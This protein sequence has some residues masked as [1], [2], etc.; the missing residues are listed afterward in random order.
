MSKSKNYFENIDIE[1]ER[2]LKYISNSEK[3]INDL[4]SFFNDI[5]SNCLNIYKSTTK[6]LSSFFDVSKVSEVITKTD[7]NMT[8]FYQTTLIF[9]N[10]FSDIV[11]KINHIIISPL[12]D[13]KINYIK[14]NTA[15]KNDL[16]LLL[17]DYKNEKKQLIL[18]QKEY[19]NSI[20]SYINIKNNYHSLENNKDKNKNYEEQ[21]EKLF[22]EMNEKKCILKNRKQL[23]KYK[24]GATNIFYKNY[25][26][27]YKKYYKSFEKNETNK[28]IF[29]HNTFRIFS[30]KIKEL[31]GV[32]ND[33]SVQVNSKISEWKIE[34]DNNI[35]KDE[36]NYIGRYINSDNIYN[37]SNT[38]QRFN[39]ELF[40]P[41]NMVNMNYINIFY[42]INEKIK[43]NSNKNNSSKSNDT[44]LEQCNNINIIEKNVIL[45]D[46]KNEEFQQNLINKFYE[47]LYN[48]DDIPYDIISKIIECI[49]NDIEFCDKFINKFYLEHK[50]K[51]Y[52]INKDKNIKHL[53]HILL[54]IFFSIKEKNET[55]KISKNKIYIKIFRIG[56][57]IYYTLNNKNEKQNIF[58][59]GLLNKYFE[60]KNHNFWE[61][62]LLYTI[63]NNL[64]KIY[65]KI[66]SNKKEN[67]NNNMIRTNTL[68]KDYKLKKLMGD[69]DIFISFLNNKDNDNE[70][71][72]T[73]EIKN[74]Y[75]Q[76]AFHKFNKIILE[77]ITFLINYNY[78]LFNSI[79]LIKKICTKF[80]LTNDLINYYLSY[81]YSFSYSIK[82]YSVNSYYKLNKKIEEFKLNQNKKEIKN[83]KDDKKLSL[84]F[85][86]KIIIILNI[87]K[88]FNNNQKIKLII[89]NKTIYGKIYKKIY[90]E[91]LY[92]S[93]NQK[94][95]SKNN[96]IHIDIWKILL[97]YKDI[98]KKYPY[99]I[100][101]KKAFSKKFLNYEQSDYYIIDLD[102]QRTLFE[103]NSNIN[104]KVSIKENN[105]NDKLL[106]NINN[107]H[108]KLIEMKRISLNNILKTIITLN[109][110]PTYC[111]GMNFIA[112][113]LLKILN[114]REDDAYYLMLGLFKC[115]SYPQI[116]HDNLYQLNLYFNIF[117]QLL[118]IFIPNLYYYFK[119]NNIIPNYYLSSFFITLF[120]N[121]ANKEKKINLF[122]KIF[123]LFIIN[124]W[125]GIFNILLEIMWYNKEKLLN[126]KNEDLLHYLN[127][128]LIND[129]LVNYNNYKCFDLNPQRKITNKLIKYIENQLINSDKLGLSVQ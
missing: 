127:G 64:Q 13:F 78:G 17:K 58:L 48:S 121:Y 116:F 31:T 128:N 10:N 34:E 88:Y 90:K 94:K 118:F 77:F 81:I 105:N 2:L 73:K 52:K 8:F 30:L 66:I 40:I 123:D 12:N 120:T 36:F 110:E 3:K 122:K 113:F 43:S 117:N 97:N 51:Y 47:C 19:Y 25:D 82:K 75:L 23:Y 65:N 46:L 103:N 16:L 92:Y 102:C 44:I 104:R 125:K 18:Y 67:N 115:T 71:L 70:K 68:K 41:Y 50:N 9:L 59:S 62:L 15:I 101:K 26:L 129:F 84:T 20:I 29:L 99:E 119:N 61:N 22:I 1:N 106:N 24:V 14:E 80:N 37:D 57:L 45:D 114:E 95:E 111:Q 49:M 60:F 38:I 32:L 4:S 27:R 33:L 124:G 35:I 112:A 28:L 72:L 87:S 39:K 109:P 21:R 91:I 89:L 83:D 79:S 86:D 108:E 96:K 126:L 69:S 11:K 42:N 5:Y 55:E 100:N 107:Y 76:N 63:N 85:E 53:Y 74:K 54:N 6:K 7:Q 93:D 56:Q 98:K